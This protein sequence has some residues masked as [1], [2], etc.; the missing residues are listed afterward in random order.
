MLKIIKK[1]CPAEKV[2]IKCPYTRTPTCIVI[3]NTANDATAENEINYMLSND[4]ET[5]FHFAVDDSKIVQGIELNR[6][7]WHAGDGN[8]PGNME[9]IAIEICFSKSGGTRFEKAQENAAELTAYLLKKYGWG[10]DRVTKHGDYSGKHCPHRTLDDYGWDFFLDLVKKYMNKEE[11]VPTADAVPHVVYAAFTDRWLKDVNDY[12]DRAAD[13]YAGVVGK[14][15][16]GFRAR[17]TAGHIRYRAHLL[18][19]NYLPWVTDSDSGPDGYA[20]IYGKQIDGIQMTLKDLPGYAVEYRVATVGGQYLK[21]VRDYGSGEEKYA[22]I[23]GQPF[24][25]LQIR[26]IRE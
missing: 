7:A 4:K 12:N 24:D 19:G 23:Y 3:H 10:I 14:A 16:T 18:G 6:N 21:W 15:V 2:E 26:L 25:R 22:G 11:K 20:G 5:S 9:G 17:T 13:G 8:G 1:D